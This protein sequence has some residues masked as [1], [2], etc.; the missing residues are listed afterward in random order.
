MLNLLKRC[1][2]VIGWIVYKL[3]RCKALYLRHKI[4]TTVN[5]QGGFISEQCNVGYPP[6]ITIG[7]NSYINGGDIIEL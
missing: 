6:H 1:V 5:N 7:R 3:D 4:N 2:Y